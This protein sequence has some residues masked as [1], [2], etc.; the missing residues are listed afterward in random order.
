MSI[1]AF[2]TGLYKLGGFIEPIP[3]S[4][5]FPADSTTTIRNDKFYFLFVLLD[6]CIT[7][8]SF[9]KD[10]QSV[11]ATGLGENLLPILIGS[12]RILVLPNRRNVFLQAVSC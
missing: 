12:Q 10:I 9:A 3:K 1:S 2:R 7:G 4:D 8:F 6:G 5:F 11:F